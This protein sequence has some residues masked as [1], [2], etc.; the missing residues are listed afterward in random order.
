[1]YQPGVKVLPRWLLVATR[2]ATRSCSSLKETHRDNIPYYI[3]R[4]E[5]STN[6]LH[7][8]QGA[9]NLSVVVWTFKSCRYTAWFRLFFSFS[10]FSRSS[11]PPQRTVCPGAASAAP[12][13]WRVAFWRRR[14]GAGTK[15][16][17]RTAFISAEEHAHNS[18]RRSLRGTRSRSRARRI[19]GDPSL[20]RGTRHRRRRSAAPGAGSARDLF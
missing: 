14:G 12:P 17:A 7:R 2:P 13:S 6:F 15:S 5:R 11:T 20:P 9:T 19:S 3:C 8:T 18:R 1:M 10:F 4:V 16:R